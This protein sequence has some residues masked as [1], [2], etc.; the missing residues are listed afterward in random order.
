[1]AAPAIAG[2]AVGARSAAGRG[3]GGAAGAGL[4]TGGPA[5]SPSSSARCAARGAHGRAARRD[6][7]SDLE[8]ASPAGGRGLRRARCAW[9]ATAARPSGPTPSRSAPALRRELAAGLGLAGRLRAWWALPPRVRASAL[10]RPAYTASTMEQV[11]RPLRSGTQPARE[12]RLPRRHRARSHAP[13]T[14]RPTRRRSARRSAGRCSA[15]SATGR[16]RAEFESVVEHAPDERLRAVLPRPLAAAARPPRRGAP[17]AR[18]G[19]A[20]CAPSAPTTAVPRPAARRAALAA[21]SVAASTSSAEQPV[22]RVRRHGRTPAGRR[23]PTRSP[24]RVVVRSGRGSASGCG[25]AARG[26]SMAPAPS[27]RAPGRAAARRAPS[28]PT[29]SGQPAGVTRQPP[30]ALGDAPRADVEGLSAASTARTSTS[31]DRTPVLSSHGQLSHRPARAGGRTGSGRSPAFFVVRRRDHEQHPDR[32]SRH[33]SR[34]PSPTS[35]CCSRRCVGG[36][37]LRLFID[38]PDGVTLELCERVTHAARRGA[39]AL[40][41]RGLLAGAPSAR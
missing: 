39:R 36:E 31:P 41:A 21:T 7:W 15:R 40:R 11:V 10:R 32:R 27:D 25:A 35:R 17:P 37:T 18:P 4:A 19:V 5:S 6:R 24:A 16:P 3:R 29:C 34:R 8:R 28:T 20:T 13:A 1:M 26:G 38:H 12:G 33:A 22:D 9:R 23:R 30:L 2:L 14:S